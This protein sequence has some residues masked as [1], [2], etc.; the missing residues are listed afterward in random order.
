MRRLAWWQWWNRHQ[1]DLVTHALETGESIKP[2]VSCR[3]FTHPTRCTRLKKHVMNPITGRSQWLGPVTECEDER[4]PDRGGLNAHYGRHMCGRDGV[5]WEI[6]P[7]AWRRWWN[8]C[9]PGLQFTI[10][11]VT[12][13][14]VLISVA[15]GFVWL[16]Q[17]WR[18]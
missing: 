12:T 17:G 3:H 18:S 14:L 6:E 11:W 8:R 16:T 1:V 9:S 5:A 4:K 7:R 13:V 2:C 10:A 15:T